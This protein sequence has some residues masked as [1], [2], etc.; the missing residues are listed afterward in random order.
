MQEGTT[1]NSYLIFGDKTAL[2]DASHE[3]FRGLYMKTLKE[4]L[5]ARGRSLDYIVV[6]HTEPDHSGEWQAMIPGTALLW[7]CFCVAADLDLHRQ[8]SAQHF[9]CGHA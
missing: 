9:A 3:K 8:A 5:A 1:Y 4:Q 6:S 7:R 2:V